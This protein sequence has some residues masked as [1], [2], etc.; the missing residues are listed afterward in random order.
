MQ[1]WSLVVTRIIDHAAREHGSRELV[2][3]WAD[4]RETRT[5]WAGVRR[6]AL[7]MTQALRRLGVQKGERIAT[8]AMNHARHLVSWYGAV[9]V[10]GVLHTVN[11]RLFDDQL[12]YIFNHAE[13]QVLLY[14]AVFQ[15]LVDRMKPRWTSV[16]HYICYDSGEHLS[17]IHI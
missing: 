14:D 1:D 13:D 8:L 16:K 3:R 4:G 9:G 7:R 6:D 10:G 5:T 2:T 17:L 12:E 15:P 11:P